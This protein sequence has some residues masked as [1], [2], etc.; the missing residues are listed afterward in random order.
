MNLSKNIY[1]TVSALLITLCLP[2]CQEDTEVYQTLCVDS[3]T[4]IK[5]DIPE[6]G[7]L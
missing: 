1:K 5:N 2:A 7:I 6:K 3:D 4:T